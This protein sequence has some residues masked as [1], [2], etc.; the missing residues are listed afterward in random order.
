MRQ[1]DN[2]AVWFSRGNY[3]LSLMPC[4]RSWQLRAATANPY[5]AGWAELFWQDYE[6][7]AVIML[8]DWSVVVWSGKPDGRCSL[9]KWTRWAKGWWNERETANWIACME[10]REPGVYGAHRV[11]EWISKSAEKKLDGYKSCLTRQHFKASYSRNAPY[12]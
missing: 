3:S 5:T 8:A 9:L 4:K 10:E 6:I 1:Y 7:W 11:C 2:I 12:L